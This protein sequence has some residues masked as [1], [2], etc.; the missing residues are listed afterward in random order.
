M[1]VIDLLTLTKSFKNE[2]FKV[3]S[4][5]NQYNI[6]NFT[7]CQPDAEGLLKM[8]NNLEYFSKNNE[9]KAITPIYIKEHYASK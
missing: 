6:K 4:F 1:K 2:T 9:Q 5:L 7:E 3:G 8:I